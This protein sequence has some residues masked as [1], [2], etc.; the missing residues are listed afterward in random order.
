MN[1]S[2]SKVRFGRINFIIIAMMMKVWITGHSLNCIFKKSNYLKKGPINSKNDYLN[3]F[4]ITMKKWGCAHL[5][6][7]P[8]YHVCAYYYILIIFCILT[9]TLAFV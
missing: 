5:T 7:H 4:V 3:K 2:Y 9:W 6:N 8:V 1:V